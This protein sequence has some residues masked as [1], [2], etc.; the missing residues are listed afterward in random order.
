MR[1]VQLE[2][3]TSNVRILMEVSSR[4]LCSL[5][6]YLRRLNGT[7]ENE[8]GLLREV[9][10]QARVLIIRRRADMLHEL[11]GQ[12]HGCVEPSELGIYPENKTRAGIDVNALGFYRFQDYIRCGIWDGG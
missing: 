10:P 12:V 2:S 6:R 8:R 5:H 3:N 7:T 1:Q 9:R 4:A 11:H